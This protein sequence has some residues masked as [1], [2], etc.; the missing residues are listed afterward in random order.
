MKQRTANYYL[1]YTPPYDRPIITVLPPPS[2]SFLL[3]LT[4]P[5]RS[6]AEQK[7]EHGVVVAYTTRLHLDAA[8]CRR[9][10]PEP[11]GPGDAVAAAADEEGR[12]L[13]EDVVAAGDPRADL[14]ADAAV[15][16]D[17]EDEVPRGDVLGE[18][19]GEVG[20][21]GDAGAGEHGRP[22]VDVAVAL[23][24][25]RQRRAGRHLL[26]LVGRVRVEAVVVHA[27]AAVGVARGEG[28]LQRGGERRG[29]VGEGQLAE[30]G[31][32][33]VEAR[34]RGAEHEVDDE[35]DDAD[36]GGQR[37]QRAQQAAAPPP[38]VVVAVVAAVLAPSLP[39]GRAAPLV[40]AAGWGEWVSFLRAL[41]G[42]SDSW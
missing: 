24:R 1:S 30:R 5:E 19:S 42:L 26:V 25:G 28:H 12:A 6:G 23:V 20:R 14:P 4:S 22:D 35:G 27:H 21:E 34:V 36:D 18:R 37:Q 11:A 10:E 13:D 38:E 15:D 17:L 33:E 7:P 8:V 9:L 39:H 2:Q 16:P 32:L 3:L 31:V 41:L 40:L 29:A